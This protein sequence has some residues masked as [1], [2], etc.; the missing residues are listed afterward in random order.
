MKISAC[1]SCHYIK[2][3][4]D[5]RVILTCNPIMGLPHED[6]W[7]KWLATQLFSIR[8]AFGAMA[9]QQDDKFK[10]KME[11]LVD[12]QLKDLREADEWKGEP[13]DDGET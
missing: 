12:R 3:S 10:K 7:H 5:G 6:C 1:G 4:N 2:Q 8:M 9:H 11:E 13:D